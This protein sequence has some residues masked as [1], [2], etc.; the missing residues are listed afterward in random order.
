MVVSPVGT[1]TE[2]GQ[3][4]LDAMENISD[5]S[6]SK[7]YLIHLEPATYDL[8]NGSLNMKQWVDIEGSGELNTVIRSVV[9][10]GGCTLGTVNGASNAEMRF[11]TVRNTGAN[12]CK[13]AI[14][15]V[16]ASPR[17][18]HLTAEAIGVG[19]SNNV[20]V[21]TNNSSTTMTDV[22]ATGSGQ[23][24]SANHGVFSSQSNLTIKQSKLTGSGGAFVNHALRI[25]SGTTAKVALSQ[26]VGSTNGDDGDTL[27]CFNN[28]NENMAGDNPDR[29]RIR[30]HGPVLCF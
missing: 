17:L 9:G 2:N 25:Q 8:G 15:N 30:G 26:L 7:P 11:L 27:Q 5:A 4:L 16:A 18:T 13:I 24:G 14:S 10:S 28:Y 22:T 6:A 3:A 1:D 19:G 12:G 21:Q 23:T 29:G 20:G